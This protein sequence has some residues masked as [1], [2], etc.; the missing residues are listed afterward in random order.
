MPTLSFSANAFGDAINAEADFGVKGYSASN[1][2]WDDKG[3]N[4]VKYKSG[5][6]DWDYRTWKPD[7]SLGRDGIGLLVSCKID[8]DRSRKDDHVVLIAAFNRKCELVCVQL[9]VQS[10]HHSSEIEP[11]DPLFASEGVD[12]YDAAK[13]SLDSGVKAILGKKDDAGLEHISA[14]AVKNLH[15]MQKAVSYK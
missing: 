14:V 8:Q 15:A 12:I 5:A 11:G 1:H 9:A 7:V 13:R 6:G 2:G 4:A 10:L 3:G